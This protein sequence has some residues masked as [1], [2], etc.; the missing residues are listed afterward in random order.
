[1]TIKDAKQ[2]I[3]NSI[4]AYL[5]KDEF[6]EYKI[7]IEHQRPCFLLGPPGIGK[8]AIMDQIAQETGIN[9]ISYSMAHQTRE[10][11][12]GLPVIVERN[13]IGADVKVSE[14]TMSEII[15]NIYNT[16]EA[17]G[18][19]E[20]ILFLD[21][22]NCVSE[23]LAPIMLQFLQYKIFGLHQI[24]P[25][26]VIVTAGNPPQFNKS[27]NE[28]DIV[29]WDRFK[30][31]ECDADFAVWKE[32]A[33][34]GGVHPAIIAYLELHPNHYYEIGGNSHDYKIV[35]ARAWEDL[36]EMIQLYEIDGTMAVTLELVGQYIQD[37]EIAPMFHAFYHKFNELRE[38]YDPDGILEGTISQEAVDRAAQ[39]DTEECIALLNLLMDGV[40]YTMRTCIQMEKM[41]RQIHPK[42]EDILIKINEGLSCRQIIAEHIMQTRK[43][44]D[45]MTKART[46][47][48]SNKKIQHWIIHNLEAYLDKCTNEGRDNKQRCTIIIQN[49]FTN[50][51]NGAKNVTNQSLVGL[52]NM[53][54]FIEAAYGAESNVMKKLITELTVN[55]HTMDF[56][57]K[58]GSDE[59]YRLAG[60]PAVPPTY[61]NMYELNLEDCLKV[62]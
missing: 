3:K 29:T 59:Y 34:Y 20:G 56:I 47:S 48:P 19:R 41:I 26:W 18:I 32:Y 33:Y 45:R 4:K 53:F 51:L 23:S 39:A 11:S 44:L 7:S 36:S 8:T 61:N 55:C 24:P 40:T 2:Q 9:L 54:I 43:N 37:K 14:Y 62:D 57:K 17:T 12:M 10:T 30:K 5:I 21:E 16:M 13:F 50:L 28:F 60:K 25:G 15:A 49:A 22:I 46:I 6:G 42:L 38:I 1:M 58:Y 27:V 52:K 31:V 35:T